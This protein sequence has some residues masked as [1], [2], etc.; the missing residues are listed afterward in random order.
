[1]KTD[2]TSML[3]GMSMFFLM[4]CPLII[5]PTY[6]QLDSLIF[7]NGDR[8]IGEVKEMDK[9]VLTFETDYSDSDFKIAWNEIDRVYTETY[10][11]ITL[12][13]GSRYN[14]SIFS[15]DSVNVNIIQGDAFEN[16]PLR[17]IVFL[18]S[19][20]ADFW[21]KFYASLD[22]GY[23]LTKAN[24]LQQFSVRSTFGY[25]AA[26][27]SADASYNNVYSSREDTKAV[28]RIDANITYRFFLPNDYYLLPQVSWLSNTEQNLALR[29]TSKLGLG[30][31]LIHTNH[32]YWG[33]QAGVSF[34]NEDFSSETTT[35]RSGEGFIGTELNMYDIGDLNLLTN[36]VAYPSLTESGRWRIDYTFDF[37][38]DLPLDFY[39]NLG[40][41]LNYDN[42]PADNASTTD[43]VIQTSFGWEL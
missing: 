23:S 16:I 8:L 9:G 10:F 33:V 5:S 6:A 4:L 30:K 43:Y 24:Q 18:K 36:I 32:T 28:R 13:D 21:S 17:T 38:Y 20:D 19:V 29:T 25:L 11:L 40:F 26:R 22:L 42:Q 31:Y 2:N 15:T 3:A 12:T 7:R 27:W 35:R 39:I 14:G 34:N 37:K 41:T 1:M